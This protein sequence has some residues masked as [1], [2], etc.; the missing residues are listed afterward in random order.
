MAKNSGRA[1]LADLVRRDVLRAGEKILIHR[2]SAPS[3]EATVTTDGRIAV[4]DMM[5]TTPTGAA[6]HSLDIGS[7]DGWIRWRVPRLDD[8]TLAD[9]RDSVSWR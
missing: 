4:G 6:K 9:L 5:F 1:S 3:I 7:V 8:R 2:R